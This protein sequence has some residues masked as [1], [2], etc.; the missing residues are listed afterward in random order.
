M[1]DR[2]NLTLAVQ[3]LHQGLQTLSTTFP[4]AEGR[5]K[6]KIEGALSELESIERAL[7]PKRIAVVGEVSAGK[8]TFLTHLLGQRPDLFR[9]GCG[10]V[11]RVPTE[12][13]FSPTDNNQYKVEFIYIT[14]EEL[15]ADIQHYQQALEDNA[16]AD[17]EEDDG[18][19]THFGFLTNHLSHF[20]R[21]DIANHSID[22]NAPIAEALQY[23]GH[24]IEVVTGDLETIANAI[25]V[26]TEEN[27]NPKLPSLKLIRI[28]GPFE[29]LPPGVIL[30]DTPGLGDH[31]GSRSQKTLNELDQCQSIWY[32]TSADTAM[33]REWDQILLQ[34]LVHMENLQ[35]DIHIIATKADDESKR[36]TESLQCFRS[37]ML[38]GVQRDYLS[39]VVG[40]ASRVLRHSNSLPHHIAQL[41]TDVQQTL[42]DRANAIPVRFTSVCR[43]FGFEEWRHVLAAYGEVAQNTFLE[44][45]DH[46]DN[47][48]GQLLSAIADST[49]EV[50]EHSVAL[51][52]LVEEVQQL[53]H[54]VITERD[55]DANQEAD[56]CTHQ[57][58]KM[59]K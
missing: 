13:Q 22:F 3:T 40:V 33:A 48:L 27:N 59:K 55:D 58:K 17:N 43:V 56:D 5:V 34:R 19:D 7:S 8:S 38:K 54:N 12:I 23:V 50:E 39:R 10:A 51:K 11:T 24:L 31:C 35:Q 47:L 32:A 29:H 4:S 25:R 46:F 16:A 28:Q 57:A 45:R 42:I 20:F 30:I 18:D 14:Q 36:S 49:V 53:R 37:N 52:E 41:P 9:C 1:A 44:Q 6:E 21:Y 15:D 2:D 26:T